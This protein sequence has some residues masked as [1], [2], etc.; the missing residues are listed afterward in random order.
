MP[1][2]HPYCVPN[3]S[4][5]AN[6]SCVV[7]GIDVHGTGG[8]EGGATGAAAQAEPELSQS[9]APKFPVQE[10]VSVVYWYVPVVGDGQEAFFCPDGMDEQEGVV[11]LDDS[12]DQ[13]TAPH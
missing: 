3:T 5:L 10:A 13:S 7:D 2:S 1:Y 9:T 6:A 12:F 4:K 8:G 11:Q